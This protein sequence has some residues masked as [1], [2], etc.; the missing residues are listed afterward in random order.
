MTFSLKHLLFALLIAAS[1]GVSS[2]GAAL[3]N[4]DMSTAQRQVDEVTQERVRLLERLQGLEDQYRALVLKIEKVKSEGALRTIGGRLEL[5]NLLTK[6][7]AIADELDG[8]QSRARALD[9]QLAGHRSTLV[10][11]IDQRLSQLERSLSSASPTSRRAIVAELN[12]LRKRRA[13][14]T[15]PLPQAPSSRDVDSALRLAEDAAHPDELMAAADEIQDT[16]DQLRKRLAAIEGKLA[17]LHEARAL[18]RRA[19]SFS[20]E[21]KFFEETDRDRV[22]AR[23]ERVTVTGTKT[24]SPDPVDTS[25]SGGQATNSPPS[26]VANESGNNATDDFAGAPAMD[27]D[28]MTAEPAAGRSESPI[29]D[30]P[31]TPP[32]A[33][34]GSSDPFET[35][36]ET[37]VIDAGTDP[38]RAVGAIGTSGNQLE[39]QIKQ[40]E[41]EQQKLKK[42]ANTL[43]K[44]ATELRKRAAAEY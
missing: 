39:G 22:I 20:R 1:V 40:L 13:A 11:G 16:E 42:Q 25:N 30:A 14:Y 35:S 41:G 10:G 7:K 9:N 28:G 29:S 34:G 3:Q 2:D 24:T 18:A 43:R 44:R 19:R 23:Y 33:S 17:E 36:R 26:S 27:A 8:L 21:E 31:G 5:Q 38:S 32:V 37:I 15:K 4:S 12:D 6:S